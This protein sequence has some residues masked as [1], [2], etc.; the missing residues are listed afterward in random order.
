MYESIVCVETLLTLASSFSPLQCTSKMPLPSFFE[1][2]KKIGPCRVC[3]ECRFKILGGAKLVERLSTDLPELENNA[4]SA[5]AP[6]SSSLTCIAPNCTA[7]RVS[8]NGYC[9]VHVNEFG[10][11]GGD[12]ATSAS[13]AVKW[14]GAASVLTRVALTDKSMNLLQIDHAFKKQCSEFEKRDDFEYV[15]KGEGISEVFYDLFHA[16]HFLPFLNTICIRPRVDTDLLVAQYARQGV[17]G[18]TT[19][20]MNGRMTMAPIVEAQAS[21]GGAVSNNPFKRRDTSTPAPVAVKPKEKKTVARMFQKPGQL[22]PISAT[23]GGVRKPPPA[24]GSSSMPPPLPGSSSSGP[25][26]PPPAGGK[27]PPPPPPAGPVQA[28]PEVFKQ[29]AKQYFGAL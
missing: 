3:G 21:T 24:L 20:A 17:R 16:S 28:T 25:P 23:S 19:A 10:V 8:K 27:P 1:R 7:N 11:G 14:E 2:K 22:K 18:R 15:Y 9:A 29:R 5:S 13:I 6:S 26:P 12:L 4:A